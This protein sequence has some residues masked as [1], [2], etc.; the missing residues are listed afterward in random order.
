VNGLDDGLSGSE[1]F[2]VRERLGESVLELNT[3]DG[4]GG[5]CDLA[6]EGVAITGNEMVLLGKGS[7]LAR[8]VRGRGVGDRVVNERGDTTLLVTG[9]KDVGTEAKS[10]KVRVASNRLGRGFVDQR[11]ECGTIRKSD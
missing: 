4:I 1:I 5:E 7:E 3:L 6:V 11:R 10:A 8:L 9:G 2:A